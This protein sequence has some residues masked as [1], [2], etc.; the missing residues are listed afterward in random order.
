MPSSLLR[1]HGV[2][3]PVLQNPV[4]IVFTQVADDLRATH[5]FASETTM[6]TLCL[7]SSALLLLLFAPALHAQTIPNPSFEANS[8]TVAPGCTGVGGNPGITGWTVV[9]NAGLNPASGNS[10]ADNGAFPNG[11]NVAFVQSRFDRANGG[12]R[13]QRE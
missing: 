5:R 1:L 10:F 3:I 13:S 8:F 9:G 12:H 2:T 7:L 4:P 11:A 6:K